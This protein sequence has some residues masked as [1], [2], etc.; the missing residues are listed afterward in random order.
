M[1]IMKWIKNYFTKPLTRKDLL[2]LDVVASLIGILLTLGYW[3]Y[4]LTWDDVKNW[5]HKKKESLKFGKHYVDVE[6]E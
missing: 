3:F 1:M 6:R 2:V 5:F 4:L